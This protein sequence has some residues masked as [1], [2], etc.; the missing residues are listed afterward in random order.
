MKKPIYSVVAIVVVVSTFTLSLY[1]TRDL[2]TVAMNHPPEAAV[3][4]EVGEVSRGTMQEYYTYRGSVEAAERVTIVSKVTGTVMKMNVN[5]GDK[6]SEGDEIVTID[7]AEFV[8]RLKQAEANVQLAEAQ[9]EGNRIRHKLAQAD[10]ER[11]ERLANQGLSSVQELDS[12][13]ATRDAAKA[14][15]DLADA[16]LARMKAA[17]DEAKLNIDHTRITSPLTGYVARRHVDPG[18]LASPTTPLVTL[19]KNDPAKVVVH[20][21]ESDL[22]V[23]ETGRQA[24]VWI[25]GGATRFTGEIIRFGPTLDALTRTTVIEIVVPNPDNRLRPGMSADISVLA[26]VESDALRIPEQALFQNADGMNVFRVTG[27]TAHLVPVEIGMQEDGLAQIVSGLEEGDV[28][29]LTGQFLLKNGDEVE[30][31]RTAFSPP[32]T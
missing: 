15:I 10:F 25:A 2:G 20:V 22:L 23:A 24:Q 9:L 6:V 3:R 32:D 26:Q 31:Q 19:V 29:V 11:I 18:T 14:E 21:P 28:V 8:Q 7:D 17:E 27:S 1:L 30:I 12:A 13:A 4:V 5:L 16:Q